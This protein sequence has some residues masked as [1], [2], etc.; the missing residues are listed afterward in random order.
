MHQRVKNVLDRHEILIP[1]SRLVQRIF[2]YALATVSK[3][4]FIRTQ[5]NHF[6]NLYFP[7]ENLVHYFVTAGLAFVKTGTAKTALPR[8]LD[9]PSIFAVAFQCN[10]ISSPDTSCKSAAI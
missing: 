5:I 7:K 8:R 9:V 6:L 1:L 2:Q 4:V 3:F 10:K